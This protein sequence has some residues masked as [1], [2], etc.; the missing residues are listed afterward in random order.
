MLHFL[1]IHYAR[2]VQQKVKT[3]DSLMEENSYGTYLTHECDFMEMLGKQME[4]TLWRI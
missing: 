3:V 2:W 4:N 1:Q